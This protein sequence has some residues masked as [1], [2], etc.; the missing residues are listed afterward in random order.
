MKPG[1]SET[2]EEIVAR[3]GSNLAFALALLPPERRHDMRVFYAFCRVIDD[4]ADDRGESLLNRRK[5]LDRWRALIAGAAA[6]QGIEEEFCSL[7]RKYDLDP[8]LLNEIIDG[9]ALDLE[10]VRFETAKDLE[11]YCFKVAGAVGLISIEIFGCRN[12]KTKQYAEHLGYALQWTNIMRDV[13]EDADE[14]RIY[15]PL[16]DLEQFH[17]TPD[18]ILKK[19]VPQDRFSDLMNHQCGVAR[20]Y[21]RRAAGN[22]VEEDRPNLRSP[23]LM[24][25]IYFGILCKME[26]D[27]YR[28]FEKR[29]RLS[30]FRMMS[31]F[32][33]AKYLNH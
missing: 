32:I 8:E 33:M 15:L 22:L 16:E 6:H 12:D 18:E 21:Y 30:K 23:E 19:Q 20:N 5:A 1:H 24:R 26:K 17:I 3:S 25:R 4:V 9:V 11:R 13:A 14:G 10:P 29:Y 2:A 7:C 31:E 27:N 28:V